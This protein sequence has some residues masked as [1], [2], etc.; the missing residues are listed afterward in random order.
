MPDP[1]P[2]SQVCDLPDPGPTSQVCDVPDLITQ[3]DLCLAHN[4][5]DTDHYSLMHIVYLSLPGWQLNG[6]SGITTRGRLR[7]LRP[8]AWRPLLFLHPSGEVGEGLMGRCFWWSRRSMR[9]PPGRG[10]DG[11]SPTNAQSF[12]TP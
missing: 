9:R 4:P 1:G 12:Q 8:A 6:T 5:S 2:T 3:V 7:L 11:Q 10:G